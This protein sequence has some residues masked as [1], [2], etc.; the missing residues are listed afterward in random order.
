M[1]TTTST[2]TI[3]RINTQTV[4]SELVRR[5]MKGLILLLP[6]NAALFLPMIM[7]MMMMMMMIQIMARCR[8][9]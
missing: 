8:L 2:K 9:K 4:E 5:Q 6:Q 7:M 3:I 1:A